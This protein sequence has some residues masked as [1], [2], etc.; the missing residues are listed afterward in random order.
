MTNW[1]LFLCFLFAAVP[2]ATNAQMAVEDQELLEPDILER[3]W[4]AYRTASCPQPDAGL[5]SSPENP[6]IIKRF[7]EPISSVMV[8]RDPEKGAEILKWEQENDVDPTYDLNC[9]WIKITG[10]FRQFG[11]Q[12]YRGVLLR[13]AQALYTYNGGPGNLFR[14]SLY[15]IENWADEEIKTALVNGTDIEI[16]G[17]F[18]DL[19]RAAE[20]DEA[21]SGQKWFILGGPVPL[22]KARRNDQER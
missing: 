15:F 11:Y 10:H 4:I 1:K 19:C 21:E 17:Q 3:P 14:E 9:K 2:A 8:W 12:N 5:S 13:N 6:L 20:K 22:H 7:L 18:Y 16:V